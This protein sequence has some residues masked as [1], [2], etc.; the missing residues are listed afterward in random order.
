MIK[1]IGLSQ[2]RKSRSFCYKEWKVGWRMYR[3]ICRSKEFYN[4][5]LAGDGLD[6]DY[7]ECM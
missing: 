2:Y 3:M 5:K 6:D 4:D 7:D 1:G